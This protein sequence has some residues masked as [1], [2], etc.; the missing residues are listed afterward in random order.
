MYVSLS[1]RLLPVLLQMLTWVLIEN[2]N[3]GVNTTVPILKFYYLG[4]HSQN[5]SP[6]SSNDMWIISKNEHI[7]IWNIVGV[8]LIEMDW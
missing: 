6:T 7:I 3:I 2:Y 4:K 8:T 5:Q 1:K